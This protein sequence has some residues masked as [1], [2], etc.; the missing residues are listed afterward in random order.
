[1][2][3]ILKLQQIGLIGSI[4]SII[5]L[6]QGQTFNGNLFLFL[7]QIPWIIYSQKNKLYELL[8]LSL[9]YFILAIIGIINT[10]H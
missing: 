1:M 6:S 2:I 4:I 8:M 9:I 7:A 10:C 3:K 5:L